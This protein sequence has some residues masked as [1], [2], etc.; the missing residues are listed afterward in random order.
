[1]VTSMSEL[2]DVT[3]EPRGDAELFVDFINTAELTDG[4]PED[5]LPDAASLRDWLHERGLCGRIEAGNLSR[6][7]RACRA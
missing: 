2:H 4:R 6:V 7:H 3:A 1:M 5:H